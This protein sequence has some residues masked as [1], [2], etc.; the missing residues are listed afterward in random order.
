[1][2][3]IRVYFERATGN[4]GT[5]KQ[6]YFY[7][8]VSLCA[9]NGSSKC[10]IRTEVSFHPLIVRG[11]NPAAY[12]KSKSRSPPDNEPQHGKITFSPNSQSSNSPGVNEGLGEIVQ[13]NWMTRFDPTRG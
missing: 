11:G 5:K 8:M 9:V 7:L 10:A 6:C 4:N 1:M 12:V 13:S 3:D 2:G